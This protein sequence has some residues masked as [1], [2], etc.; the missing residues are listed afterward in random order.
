VGGEGIAPANQALLHAVDQGP[1]N[2][3]DEKSGSHGEIFP[4]A[5]APFHRQGRS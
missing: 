3:E 2:V 4:A 5:A 1:L